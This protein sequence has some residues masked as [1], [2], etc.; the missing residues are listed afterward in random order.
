MIRRRFLLGVAVAALISACGE[1]R[2][3][4]PALFTEGSGVR[5]VRTAVYDTIWSYGGIQDTVFGAPTRLAAAPDN[6]LYVLDPMLQQVVRL[7]PAGD[8]DWRWG[9]KGEGPGELGNVRA[10]DV[11][12]DGGLVL[13]DSGNCR[14]VFLSPQGLV[15]QERTIICS[16]FS[17]IEGVAALSS[18]GVVLDTNRPADPWLLVST[19]GQQDSVA[20]PWSRFAEMHFLQRYGNVA[21]SENDTWVFAFEAGNGW[22]SFEADKPLGTYPFVE[23]TEFPEIIVNRSGNSTMWRMARRPA[24]SAYDVDIWQDTMYVL[25]GGHTP[26]RL[27]VLDKYEVSSGRY[28]YSQTLPNVADGV[29]VTGDRVF[30]LD[31]RGL[32]PQITS[33]RWKGPAR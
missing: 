25:P 18:G 32:Y 14:L 30:V 4:S 6:A 21:A 23:H 26:H 8:L 11:T 31:N 33:L 19:G 10:I 15:K 27:R 3:G 12:A 16:E 1:E 28:V 22:F 7:S 13:A 5:T 17:L 9:R 2:D 20:I 24:Y 29:A